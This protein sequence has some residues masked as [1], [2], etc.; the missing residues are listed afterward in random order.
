M[1]KTAL[2][3]Q[4]SC[5]IISLTDRTLQES[6][7]LYSVCSSHSNVVPA[8][9]Y[10]VHFNNASIVGFNNLEIYRSCFNIIHSFL[11]AIN[12]V[13]EENTIH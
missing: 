8:V 1:Q 5:I 11:F 7:I 9:Q 3:C 6:Q 13:K 10:L 4:Q 12:H 2:S